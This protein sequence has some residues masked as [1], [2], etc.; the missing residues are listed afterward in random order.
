LAISHAR[1]TKKKLESD[2][3]KAGKQKNKKKGE[4]PK[5]KKKKNNQ[6][7]RSHRPQDAQIFP[8]LEAMRYG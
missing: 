6:F 8:L 7:E 1:K 2:K 5:K 3:P 4:D